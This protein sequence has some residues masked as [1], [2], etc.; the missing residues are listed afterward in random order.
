RGRAFA[1][2]PAAPAVHPSARA[3]EDERFLEKPKRPEFLD[4]DPWRALRLLSEVVEGFDALAPLGPAVAVFGSARTPAGTPS[5]ELA[6]DVGRGLARAG[7][8][9]ITGG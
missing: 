8:A 3:T 7:Y 6:R 5:Y 2:R 9:V 4:S 1:R